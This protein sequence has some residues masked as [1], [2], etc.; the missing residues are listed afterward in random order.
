M[1]IL[2]FIFICVCIYICANVYIVVL[3]WIYLTALIY[4]YIYIIL[5]YYMHTHTHICIY[6]ERECWILP[7][8]YHWVNRL[9]CLPLLSWVLWVSQV[10]TLI[11][12]YIYIYKLINVFL[13]LIAGYIPSMNFIRKVVKNI[14]IYSEPTG[15]KNLWRIY[16]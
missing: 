3:K 11:Y 14:L 4:I 7:Q 2:I 12:I 15:E 13:D 8:C 6:K 10:H 5:Y 9:T 1:H 16:S